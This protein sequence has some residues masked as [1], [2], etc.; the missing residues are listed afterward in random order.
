MASLYL[1]KV[2]QGSVVLLGSFNPAI[3]QPR[4]FGSVGAFT[5]AEVKLFEGAGELKHDDLIITPDVAQL[6]LSGRFVVVAIREQIT[7]I[8]HNPPFNWLRDFVECTFSALPHTPVRAAGINRELHFSIENPR[9]WFK[10]GDTLVP[11]G[12]WEFF[13]RGRLKTDEKRG[14]LTSVTM[15]QGRED[16][17]WPGYMDLRVFAADLASR[18]LGI[19]TNDHFDLT[20]RTN[21]PSSTNPAVALVQ[22]CMQRSTQESERLI[23]DVMKLAKECE[24]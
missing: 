5:Q 1:P 9:A 10:I 19:S 3:F 16:D 23:N 4:W 15:R 22:E 8:D 21:G 14:G 24:Q 20:H 7:I 18:T 11:K 13:F 2:D 12:A 17:A 6:R